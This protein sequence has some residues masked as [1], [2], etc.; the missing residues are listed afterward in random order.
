MFVISQL[1]IKK[2]QFCVIYV[3]YGFTLNAITSVDYQ[4]LSGCSE[5][6]YCLNC[7]S[8]KYALGNL[9]KRNFLLFIRENLT[10]SLKLNNMNRTST[11]VLKQPENLS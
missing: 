8:Q 6:W 5:S 7:N 10:D 4:Y 3:N 1:V 2:T 9:N 11:L